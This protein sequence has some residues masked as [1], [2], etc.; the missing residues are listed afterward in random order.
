[1]D[2]EHFGN[3]HFGSL[4]PPSSLVSPAV[5]FALTSVPLMTEGG[6]KNCRMTDKT[7]PQVNLTS[8]SNCQ[9]STSLADQVTTTLPTIAV[10]LKKERTFFV[11]RDFALN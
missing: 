3:D 8:W 6:A 5:P 9:M 11:F 10:S 7:H 4:V 1:M 2:S